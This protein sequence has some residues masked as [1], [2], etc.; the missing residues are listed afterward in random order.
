MTVAS[1]TIDPS[2]TALVLIEY[3]NDFASEGGTLHGAVS[4]VMEQTGMLQ[5]T[6][7]LVEKARDAGATTVRM[8]SCHRGQVDRRVRAMV[9][10]PG[11]RIRSS[12]EGTSPPPSLTT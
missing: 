4:E 3:Q 7:D 2:S 6:V 12:G 1:I 11:R 9:Q 10:S 5:N 8:G